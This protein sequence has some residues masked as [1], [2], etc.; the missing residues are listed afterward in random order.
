MK[1]LIVEDH[2]PSAEALERLLSERMRFVQCRIAPNPEVG[3]FMAR[4]LQAD[5]TIMD[6]GFPD[7][8]RETVIREFLPRYPP[9]V[10]IVSNAITDDEAGKD[11][12]LECYS[13]GAKG[14]NVG[15]IDGL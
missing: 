9:P 10:V 11:L 14:N 5:I 8:T 6:I 2:Q 15:T 7:F 13:F 3:L 12:T 1:I 4:E